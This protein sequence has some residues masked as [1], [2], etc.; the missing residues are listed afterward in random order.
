MCEGVSPK[1][2]VHRRSCRQIIV[3]ES[4]TAIFHCQIVDNLDTRKYKEK[5]LSLI[6]K[7]DFLEKIFHFLIYRIFLIANSDFS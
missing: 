2:R 7:S 1:N 5:E 4:V 3:L 6:M